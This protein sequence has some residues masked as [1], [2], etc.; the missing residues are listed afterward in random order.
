[1]MMLSSQNLG[2]VKVPFRSK[3]TPFLIIAY[4]FCSRIL[5]I[6][7][8]LIGNSGILHAWGPIDAAPRADD[9][10]EEMHTMI[11]PAFMLHSIMASNTT[12]GL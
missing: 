1:M 12:D 4:C 10:C 5:I 8:F 11:I 6:R 2:I 3:V 9:F 7:G